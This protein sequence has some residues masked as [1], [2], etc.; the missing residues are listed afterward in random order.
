MGACLLFDSC[1]EHYK[2]GTWSNRSTCRKR[3][4]ASGAASAANRAAVLRRT[5]RACAPSSPSRSTITRSRPSS[6]SAARGR[7]LNSWSSGSIGRRRITHGSSRPTSPGPAR[8]SPHGSAATLT[9]VLASRPRPRRSLLL[10]RPSPLQLSPAL[11]QLMLL[12]MTPIL[13]S[14]RPLTPLPPPLQSFSTAATTRR[15]PLSPS[16]RQPRPRRRG[17]SLRRRS[18]LRRCARCLRHGQRLHRSLSQH[19]SLR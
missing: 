15:R 6:H 7:A 13:L 1:C 12:L 2:L 5:T 14:P 10:W 16:L 11:L 18:S 19:R 8:C 3:S 17:R 9:Q 4:C